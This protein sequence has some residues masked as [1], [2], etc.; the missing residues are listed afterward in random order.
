[1]VINVQPPFNLKVIKSINEFQRDGRFSPLR[2]SCD[3]NGKIF[4]REDGLV[5]PKC[6]NVLEYCPGWIANGGWAKFGLRKTANGND[7]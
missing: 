2:C 7:Q 5:C 3:G 1:M 4:G 6:H